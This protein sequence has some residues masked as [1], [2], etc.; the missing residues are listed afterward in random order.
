MIKYSI[1][2]AYGKDAYINT[3]IFIKSEGAVIVGELEDI[4]FTLKMQVDQG[5]I[6][7]LL[8]VILLLRILLTCRDS[9]D[10]PSIN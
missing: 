10:A 6:V 4:K 5:N 7:Y 8:S 2:C 3:T 1:S 9:K